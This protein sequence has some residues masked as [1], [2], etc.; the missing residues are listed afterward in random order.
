MHGIPKR[1]VSPQRKV[2]NSSEVKSI[3]SSSSSGSLLSLVVPPT[4]VAKNTSST[5]TSLGVKRNQE[6]TTIKGIDLHQ[7]F[8]KLANKNPTIGK[9]RK[10]S[11]VSSTEEQD[12][13]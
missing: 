10:T 11:T 8:K 5:T 12:W 13:Q 6:E 4:R 3:S 2:N 1:F 9:Q 7:E